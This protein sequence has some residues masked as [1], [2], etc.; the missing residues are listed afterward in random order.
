MHL[1]VD[2]LSKWIYHLKLCSHI[3]SYFIINTVVLNLFQ[4]WYVNLGVGSLLLSPGSWYTQGSVCAFQESISQSCVS[5]GRSMV[6]LMATPSKRTYAIPRSAAPRAPVPVALHCWPIPPQEMLK[7]SSVSVFAVTPK[8]T[9]PDLPVRVQESP[10]EAW[11]GGGLLQG[12]GHW[13]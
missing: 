13:V 2:V 12:W 1:Q 9:D 3:E 10:V 11:V 5:S 8:E 4:K 7:H 6:G